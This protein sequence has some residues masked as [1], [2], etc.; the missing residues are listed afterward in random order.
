MNIIKE[1]KN[2]LIILENTYGNSSTDSDQLYKIGKYL[3]DDI[4]IGVF[5]SDKIPRLKINQCCILNTDDSKHDRTHWCCL[6]RYKD[7][8]HYFYDSYNRSYKN[9]SKYWQKRHWISA[10]TDID[11]SY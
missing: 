4:F 7:G 8:H 11:Q 9:L 6:Y 1:Y 10:N 3:F 5:A 2:N